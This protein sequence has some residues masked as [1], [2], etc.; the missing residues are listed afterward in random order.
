VQDAARLFGFTQAR[1][2]SIGWKL[3]GPDTIVADA[4]TSFLE[5]HLSFDERSL[6]VNAGATL[7][8]DQ[9]IALAMRL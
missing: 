6:L 2:Q 7:D 3:I 1:L 4:F 9:A 8:E 5:Q